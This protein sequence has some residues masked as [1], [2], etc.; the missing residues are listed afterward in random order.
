MDTLSGA[1]SRQQFYSFSEFLPQNYCLKWSKNIIKKLF[2]IYN[3]Q[4]IIEF[5]N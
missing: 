2:D 3:S 5:N 1:W 4:K